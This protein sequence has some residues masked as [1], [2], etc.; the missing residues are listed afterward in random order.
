MGPSGSG[1]ST[2][3]HILAGLD[4]PTSRL[5]RDRRHAAR[6]AGRPRAHAA[7]PRSRSASS[8]RATTCCRSSPPRRT[9]CCRCEIAGATP[10]RAWLET[11]IDTVGL[12]DRRTHRP[13]ELSGGQQQ[14]VAVA[15]ALITPPGGRVRRRADRQPRLRIRAA[16]CS[17]LLRRAV[18]ELG[19][20]IVM[21]T[22]DA[23]AA[24]IADRSSSSPTGASST[25]QRR[26]AVEQILDH[27]KTLPMTALALRSIGAAQAALGADRDR[28]PARRRDD[29]RHV[30]PDGPDHARVRGHRSRPPTAGSTSSSRPT[31]AFTSGTVSQHGD[32]RPSERSSGCATFPASTAVDG[33]LLEFGQLVVRRR[34]GRDAGSAGLVVSA[35]SPS[36]STRP[37][38]CRGAA[39]RA[40]AR[41]RARRQRRG[42]AA[43][44]GRR[45]SASRPAHGVREVR[46]VG[47]FTFGGSV[48]RRRDDRRRLARR[49][50]SAGTTAWARYTAIQVAALPGVTPGRAAAP[51][52]RGAARRRRRCA[53]APSRRSETAD[54]I[55]DAIGGFL[56]PALLAFAGAALLV[57]AFIIFNTFSITVAQRRREFALLRA[58]GATRGQVLAAVVA[59]RRWCSA[60]SPRSLGLVAGLGFARLLERAVRRGRL[61]HPARGHRARAAHDRRRRSPSGSASRSLAAIVPAIRATRVPPVAAH[62]ATAPPPA[63]RSARRWTAVVASALIGA[64]GLALLLAGP[65]RLRPGD[66]PARAHGAAARCSSSSASRCRRATSC[67]R[68][69]RAIGWPLA[70]DLRDAR[71][72]RARERDAQPRPHRGH[73]GRAD[74]RPRAR[75]VRRG[76]RRRR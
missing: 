41:W 62:A 45:G 20:T 1:K 69:P 64:A 6:R 63:T 37:S 54:E 53:P 13:V 65:V 16:R 31:Q 66:Q 26:L 60:S 19:Q 15:R 51:D 11:L 2:L 49:T 43:R 57:G 46:V 22:H 44:A 12:G 32:A 25:T 10:D 35:L 61:R 34:G 36:R 59:A 47:T 33:E 5:G 14:R 30:R 74:G 50:C 40:A 17:T 58:L 72:A 29:R 71:R 56:T 68:S 28:D 27:L 8:S 73:V 55:N 42:R 18:D 23:G 7:A 75:R 52:R 48:A 76:V 39:R 70:A 67:A 24:A 4:R 38:S 9:S 21:V 3:L